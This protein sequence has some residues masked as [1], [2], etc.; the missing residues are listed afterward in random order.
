M[1]NGALLYDADCPLLLGCRLLNKKK[2]SE[3]VRYISNEQ[4]NLMI[5]SS[6]KRGRPL[7]VM[8]LLLDFYCSSQEC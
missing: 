6:F 7:C 3:S 2:K 1:F 4:D 8:G 5:F